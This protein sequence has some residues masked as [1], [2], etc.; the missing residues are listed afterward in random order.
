MLSVCLNV[1]V[2]VLHEIT[3]AFTIRYIYTGILLYQLHVA[4][5][6]KQWIAQICRDALQKISHKRWLMRG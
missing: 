2:D 4:Y 6:S 1:S 5:R 3:S